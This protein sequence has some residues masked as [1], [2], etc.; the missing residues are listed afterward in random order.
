MNTENALEIA[1]KTPWFANC[2]KSSESSAS[3]IGSWDEWA[4]PEDEL[5]SEIHYKQQSFHDQLV[6]NEEEEKRWKKLLY[7]LLEII[8]CHAPYIEDED[9]CYAP[10][11]AVWQAA[12][13]L[14]LVTIFEEK[15]ESVP[16]EVLAQWAWFKKGRWPCSLVSPEKADEITGYVIY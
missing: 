9:A 12:W 15:S 6:T 16:K 8:R 14:A 3:T 1:E 2:G 5:V 11:I 4:G 10:N 13:V 7:S